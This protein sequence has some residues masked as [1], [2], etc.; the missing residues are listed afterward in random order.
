MYANRGKKICLLIII[1]YLA[2]DPMLLKMI[3]IN[4]STFDSN[5]HGFSPSWCRLGG[6]RRF[7][8]RYEIEQ[9]R[10]NLGALHQVLIQQYNTYGVPISITLTLSLTLTLAL[11]LECLKIMQRN[12]YRQDNEVTSYVTIHLTDHSLVSTPTLQFS[13]QSHSHT[14]QQIT[15][16]LHDMT[17]EFKV[18]T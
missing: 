9:L 17:K 7:M 2:D 8:S 12:N 14:I 4:S 18:K 1:T 13:S 16:S 3:L 6:I 10:I 5:I 11:A 15:T